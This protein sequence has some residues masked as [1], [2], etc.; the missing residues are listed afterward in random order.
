MKKCVTFLKDPNFEVC[1][2]KTA[3][4]H[5]LSVESWTDI[6]SPNVGNYQY[7]LR[8]ITEERRPH[9]QHVVYTFN[10][11]P[12]KFGDR[13]STRVKVLCYKSEGRWL[14]PS[15]CLWNFSLT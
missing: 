12:F 6:V 10:T 4:K 14:D 7:T 8:N 9:L 15:W 5:Y 3:V 1:G 13:R 11:R 2:N